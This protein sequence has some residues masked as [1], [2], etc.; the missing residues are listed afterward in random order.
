MR[1]RAFGGCG[2]TGWF[3]Q[4]DIVTAGT[5]LSWGRFG[6][7][8]VCLQDAAES[9]AVAPTYAAVPG[10]AAATAPLSRLHDPDSRLEE[11]GREGRGSGQGLGL[12]VP[13][14]S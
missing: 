4:Q 11:R 3:C 2:R 12:L 1:T 14:S 8:G 9:P 6:V 10:P 13:K 5:L 7:L